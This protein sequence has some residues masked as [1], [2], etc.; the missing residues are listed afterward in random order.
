MAWWPRSPPART[1]TR[2]QCRNMYTSSEHVLGH[3]A[4]RPDGDARSSRAAPLQ[5]RREIIRKVLHRG[6][7]RVDRV[8]AEAA[9]RPIGNVARELLQ[10]RQITLSAQVAHDALQRASDA[11]D[12]E[13]AG[14]G[15]R[16]GLA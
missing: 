13:P 9:E 3:I 6:V 7:E 14:K 8:D 15:A 1:R 11:L 12:A 2:H 10:E 16:T 5:V 4:V